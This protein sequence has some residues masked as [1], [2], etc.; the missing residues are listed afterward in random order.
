[1]LPAYITKLGLR[2]RKIGVS[3]QK[4]NR[5]HLDTFEIVIVDCL[6]KNK[7]ERI[8]FFQKIF[9]LANI[10]L[11][12]VLKML[13][14]TFSKADIWFAEQKFVWMIYIAAEALPTIRKLEI[15]DKMK[16]AAATLNE[17][18]KTFIVH[19]VA[20]AKLIT[21]PIYSFHYA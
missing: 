13:F 20:L 9:L 8:R 3:A 18:N 17:D 4:I 12:I 2:I 1:M 21:I 7:F 16:F 11:E 5:S 10:S 15:I 14:L 6:V 19:I